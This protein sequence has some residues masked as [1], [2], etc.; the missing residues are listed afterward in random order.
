MAD[1][2][3]IEIEEV[4]MSTPPV[5]ESNAQREIVVT[6]FWVP[7]NE[8]G[9]VHSTVVEDKKDEP[10]ITVQ[11]GMCERAF[12]FF[13]SL[14]SFGACVS[15][16][17][18]SGVARFS[19]CRFLAPSTPPTP[20]LISRC[21]HACPHHFFLGAESG[22]EIVVER[23]HVFPANP[24]SL[25]GV[26][27]NTQL[28]HLHEASLLHNMR[29]RYENQDIYTYTA[30]ILAAVNPY[31]RL[32][33][34]GDEEVGGVPPPL[35]LVCVRVCACVCVC[36]RVCALVCVCVAYWSCTEVG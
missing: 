11:T 9:Y 26:P 8:Q 23:N 29:V 3:G 19:V 13:F 34:Y 15:D 33:I 4:P 5:S 32:S 12:F 35:L 24:P 10:T 36:V 28:M 7:D 22:R 14:R 27:D 1:T 31:E 6:E 30:Y 21:I 18:W 16:V 2:D 25:D 17:I 20:F